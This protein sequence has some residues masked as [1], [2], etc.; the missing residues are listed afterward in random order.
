MFGV[1]EARVV[2]AFG[3]FKRGFQWFC[4][5]GVAGSAQSA[6]GIVEDVLFDRV[7]GLDTSEKVSVA[8]LDIGDDAK[9]HAQCYNPTRVRHFRKLMQSLD[10]P[11]SHVFVDVGCGKGRI[12]V[13]AAQLGFRRVVGIEISPRL[14]DIAS[15]N[16]EVYQG[17][18]GSKSELEVIC[19]NISDFAMRNDESVFYLFWPFDRPTTE[20]FLAKVQASLL[21]SPRELWII[22]NNPIYPDLFA[23]HFQLHSR[24]LYG[25]STF[26]I[27][28][29]QR[30]S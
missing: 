8:E 19:S 13:A 3:L 14:S 22:L 18:S 1:A 6:I 4:Q 9:Q 21:A 30:A 27:Y 26:E 5:R 29:N 12:L 11:A 24:F 20:T 15:H 2:M 16:I 7:H 17:R 23:Q 10:L 25:G 28:R